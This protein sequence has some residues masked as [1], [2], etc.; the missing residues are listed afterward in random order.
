MR[1]F[2]LFEP[3]YRHKSD[4]A[5]C[6]TYE[7]IIVMD[8]E[9]VN[10]GIFHVALTNGSSRHIKI[11]YGQI[12][13]MLK[14]CNEDNIC[15]IHKIAIFQLTSED[16]KPQL[17]EKE[18]YCVPI[19][20]LKTGKL[21]LTLSLKRMNL[22]ILLKQRGKDLP[23]DFVTYK[24]PRLRDAPVNSRILQDLE[25][26]LTE[27][28]ETFADDERGIGVTPLIIMSIDTGVHPPIAKDLTH[29]L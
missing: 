5:G 12:M 23:E 20:N 16:T 24:K 21:R 25:Q 26:L 4:Y 9:I 17:V 19:R 29:C 18:M 13:G 27:N 2:C 15:T 28:K 10:S 7:G 1:K 11:N 6:H 8:N 14:S 22:F 3:S